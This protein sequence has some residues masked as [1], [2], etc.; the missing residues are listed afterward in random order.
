MSSRYPYSVG[1]IRHMM[2]RAA[3][4]DNLQFNGRRALVTGGTQG[5]GKAVVARLL[6][7]GATVLATARTLS[8][9]LP[10]TVMFVAPDIAT[11]AGCEMGA[12]AVRG[13]LRGGAHLPHLVAG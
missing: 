5:I 12:E 1:C 4:S 6:E 3:M 11:V 7:A 8:A 10:E 13:R 2:R 9:E